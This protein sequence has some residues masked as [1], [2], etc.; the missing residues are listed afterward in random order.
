MKSKKKLTGV[1][2]FKQSL[3]NKTCSKQRF[4]SLSNYKHVALIFGTPMLNKMSLCVRERGDVSVRALYWIDGQ[5]RAVW[6]GQLL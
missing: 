3:V 6:V 5:Q 2:N 1:Q 4:S